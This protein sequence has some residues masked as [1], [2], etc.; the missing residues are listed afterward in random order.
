MKSNGTAKVV[1]DIEGS[2]NGLSPITNLAINFKETTLSVTPR[3][4]INGRRLSMSSLT[5][6]TPVG[7]SV[8][9]D[10]PEDRLGTPRLTRNVLRGPGSKFLMRRMNSAPLTSTSTT[11]TVSPGLDGNKENSR[12]M[13][14]S[15]IKRDG[16]SSMVLGSP[17]RSR[18]L[19]DNHDSNSQD[20]GYAASDEPQIGF[21]F[22]EPS[23][24]APKKSSIEPSPMKKIPELLLS[25]QSKLFTSTTMRS[26]SE[27]KVKPINFYSTESF[28]DGF[29]ELNDL[30]KSFT[31]EN[32][33]LPAGL[34]NLLTGALISTNLD[35]TLPLADNDTPIITTRPPL[36]RT[37]SMIENYT[38]PASSKAK[39]GLFRE[40]I[41]SPSDQSPCEKIPFK[42][43]REV[44]NSSAKRR[45]Y[46]SLHTLS[47]NSPRY[48][49]QRSISETA[50]TSLASVLQK[51]D[52]IADFSRPYAL[53]IVSGR[54]EDLKSITSDTL[55]NLINGSYDNTISSF[56]I[57]DCRY[58]Y[59]YEGGHIKG[60]L[61]LYTREQVQAELF[62]GTS[63]DENSSNDRNILI[64]HCEFSLERGPTLSRFLRRCDRSISSYPSLKY[65]EVYLL[66]GGYESFFSSHKTLCVPCSYQ[67]MVDPKHENDLRKFRV[68]SNSWSGDMKR[69]PGRSSLKRLGLF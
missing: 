65:P 20:S 23:G 18:T 43:P 2:P 54:H 1:I 62:N 47:E 19:F 41:F 49:L 38:S 59:E 26:S 51:N 40:E 8:A 46:N 52:L 33:E 9:R 25:P 11:E 32:T 13:L 55:A 44:E 27:G 34:G 60:S 61:N 6:D 28:D 12:G 10:F 24:F 16:I 42:R 29:L 63:S 67:P 17:L 64:F 31:D 3:L 35:E 68:K 56:K 39:M 22:A 30:D 50:A 48:K 53:P 66:H 14:L 58:P 21:R 45:K 7:G 69:P 4:R 5:P 57:I 36:R 15:P 37:A